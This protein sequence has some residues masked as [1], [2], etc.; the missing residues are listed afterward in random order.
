[1]QKAFILISFCWLPQ[2]SPIRGKLQLLGVGR[3]A[4]HFA[5]PSSGRIRGRSTRSFNSNTSSRRLGSKPTPGNGERAMMALKH[6]DGC[7]FRSFFFSVATHL[8]ESALGFPCQRISRRSSSVGCLIIILKW[9]RHTIST[10]SCSG[11]SSPG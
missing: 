4:S 2:E 6:F 9:L 1:M 8:S 11:L 5:K 3:L 7:A 10:I